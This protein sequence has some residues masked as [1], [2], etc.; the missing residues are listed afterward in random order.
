MAIQTPYKRSGHSRAKERE[1]NGKAKGNAKPVNYEK[2]H[3]NL[4]N[5]FVAIYKFSNP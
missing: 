3:K 4:F 5:N 1:W 2:W